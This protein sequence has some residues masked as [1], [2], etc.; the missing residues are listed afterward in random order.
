MYQTR[1]DTTLEE[2]VTQTR[3]GYNKLHQTGTD[4]YNKLHQTGTDAYGR[5]GQTRTGYRFAR[6]ELDFGNDWLLTRN[7]FKL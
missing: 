1:T 7:R 3:T 6:R 5:V 2:T 4:A